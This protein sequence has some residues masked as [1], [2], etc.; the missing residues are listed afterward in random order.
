MD[1]RLENLM[2][3]TRRGF[4]GRSGASLGLAALATLLDRGQAAASSGTTG[5]LPGLPHFPARAKR[6]ISLF[7]SGAPSQIDLFDFKPGLDRLRGEELPPS[8]RQG[9]RLTGMTA[10]QASFPVAPSRFQFA[11]HGQSGTW[12]SELLP[13]TARI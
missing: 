9:Q 4:L 13:H 3:L 11:R 12:V 10:T 6:V 7:Q 2:R 5:G 8:I 1:P